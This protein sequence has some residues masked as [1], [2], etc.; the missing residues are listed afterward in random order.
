MVASTEGMSGVNVPLTA[1]GSGHA[2][3]IVVLND[4]GGGG[5]GILFRQ[6]GVEV[7]W[8]GYEVSDGKLHWNNNSGSHV[9]A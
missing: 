5:F 6:N 3:S 4:T 9:I 7:G 1:I 8:L 2:G